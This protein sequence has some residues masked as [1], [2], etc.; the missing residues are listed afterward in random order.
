MR[1]GTNN[2]ISGEVNRLV[3]SMARTRIQGVL[4]ASAWVIILLAGCYFG[5]RKL[6][7]PKEP[8]LDA[9]I[10]VPNVLVSQKEPPK[11]LR[12]AWINHTLR[13][14]AN[15]GKFPN[16]NTGQVIVGW[17][18]DGRTNIAVECGFREDGVMIWRPIQP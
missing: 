3:K 8:P 13:N 14:M 11:P 15:S 4:G 10:E 6:W 1:T 16:M 7:P 17:L 5:F 2:H 18:Y 12:V 9:L